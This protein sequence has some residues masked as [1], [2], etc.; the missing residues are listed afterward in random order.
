MGPKSSYLVQLVLDITQVMCKCFISIFV[1]VLLCELDFI[2][3]GEQFG[4]QVKFCWSRDCNNRTAENAFSAPWYFS[5][6]ELEPA[7]G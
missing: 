2:H 7:T 3:E 6:M 1:N 4:T 5:E